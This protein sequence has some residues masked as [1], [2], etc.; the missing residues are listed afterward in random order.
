VLLLPTTG[1]LSFSPLYRSKL[2]TLRS[3]GDQCPDR[4]RLTEPGLLFRDLAKS[5][6]R[7]R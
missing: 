5:F 7:W 4:S 2:T 3:P 6:T 1:I